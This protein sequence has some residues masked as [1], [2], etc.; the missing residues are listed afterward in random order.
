MTH[1]VLAPSSRTIGLVADDF[2]GAMDSGAQFAYAAPDVFLRFAG[3]PHYAVEIVN[4]ASREQ[5]EIH[6]IDRH[7]LACR[8]L[9][10]RD[11]FKKIDSTLRGHVGAEV[12]TMLTVMS[13]RYRKAVICPAAPLQG[14]TVIA[15][16]L[17]VHGVPLA[18]SAF[19]HDP[20]YPAR[21]SLLSELIRRPTTH[22]A[23]SAVRGPAA[24]LRDHIMNAPTAMVTTDAET[25]DDL[26][27]VAEAI[28]ASHSLPCGAFGLAHAY[29]RL[30]LPS[31]RQ[32]TTFASGKRILVVV[33]SANPM[34]RAQAAALAQHPASLDC[35]VDGNSHAAT[36]RTMIEAASEHPRIIILRAAQAQ[37]LHTPEWLGF[38]RTVSTLAADLLESLAIDTVV[39]VG[40]ETVTHLSQIV[41]MTGIHILGEAAPGVPFGRIE[42]GRCAGLQLLTKAGGFGQPDTLVKML[43]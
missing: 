25:S 18:E 13:H 26:N 27:A 43:S 23:L 29:M 42:G 24:T 17:S 16:Q 10:G 4:A 8:L 6:A 3:Q 34:A 38:G 20:M 21:S 19:Q 33:G 28:L 32:H 37:T 5:H 7:R 14:R 2:T 36:I 41:Q 40:G 35:P 31:M 9:M 12:E 11:L 30:R 22:L 1:S 39:M 15:G